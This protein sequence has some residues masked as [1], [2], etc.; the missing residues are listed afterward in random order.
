MFPLSRAKYIKGEVQ[1]MKKKITKLEIIGLCLSIL[2][3]LLLV[4]PALLGIY[5]NEWSPPVPDGHV[6]IMLLTVFTYIGVSI[7][8][9]VINII[10]LSNNKR[11]SANTSIAVIGLI[12]SLHLLIILAGYIV[13]IIVSIFSDVY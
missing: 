10:A 4:V 3:I 13:R 8:A 1:L 12:L 5:K 11:N 9:F 7:A 6:M 2:S